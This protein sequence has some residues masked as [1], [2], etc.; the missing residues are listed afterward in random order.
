MYFKKGST[1]IYSAVNVEI[2]TV[3]QVL[4]SRW[5]LINFC[6]HDQRTTVVSLQIEYTISTEVICTTLLV[7]YSVHYSSLGMQEKRWE[8]IWSF[9]LLTPTQWWLAKTQMISRDCLAWTQKSFS[10]SH[11]KCSLAICIVTYL[12]RRYYECQGTLPTC[13]VVLLVLVVVW[14]RHSLLH[15]HIHHCTCG[16]LR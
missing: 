9:A 4:N 8:Y 13:N 10:Y 16:E 1:I 6:D 5:K 15:S 12:D 7:W 3:F 14:D 11:S 2:V